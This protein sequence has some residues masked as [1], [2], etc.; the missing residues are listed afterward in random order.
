MKYRKTSLNDI[1][2]CKLFQ[3]LQMVFNS[4][5][6]IVRQKTVVTLPKK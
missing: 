4:A 1:E 3:D 2:K 5:L 6:G